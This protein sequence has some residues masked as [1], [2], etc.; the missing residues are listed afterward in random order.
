[1]LLCQQ[2][3]GDSNGY[4]IN[5]RLEFKKSNESFIMKKKTNFN[6]NC[7]YFTYFSVSRCV[8]CSYRKSYSE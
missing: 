4:Y 8:F 1:M 3:E 7:F 2:K 6:N 5:S